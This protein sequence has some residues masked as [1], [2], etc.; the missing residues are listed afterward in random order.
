MK[1]R[2]KEIRLREGKSRKQVAD[3]LGIPEGTYRNWE[4]GVRG[5]NAN[6]MR[7]LADYYHLDSAD[8]IYERPPMRGLLDEVNAL[9]A[10]MTDDELYEIRGFARGLIAKR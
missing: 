10:T 2:L 4:Q 6:K 1:P 3:D 8:E 9:L 5:L 7:M